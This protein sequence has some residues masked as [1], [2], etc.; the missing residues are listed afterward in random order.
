MSYQN[1]RNRYLLMSAVIAAGFLFALTFIS[2]D[3]DADDVYPE[4]GDFTYKIDISG[5]TAGIY[6]YNGTAGTVE[7]PGSVTYEGRS[8]SIV[9]ICDGAFNSKDVISVSIP[10]GVETIGDSAF[11][12]CE[13]LTT[14]NIPDSVT[15]L[16]WGCFRT[17]TALE[18]VTFG[19]DP[20]LTTLGSS[21]FNHCYKLAS[22]TIPGGVTV[23]NSGTFEGCS[24]FTAVSIHDGITSIEDNAF[25]DC[26]GLTAVYF[27]HS[28]QLA[29]IDNEAFS[30]CSGLAGFSLP[31]TVTKV[32]Y[33]AFRNTA[34]TAIDLSNVTDLGAEA[35]EF[36]DELNTVR[37]NSG[38][39]TIEDSL[40]EG[41]SGLQSIDI[42]A[43]VTK[44]GGSA[45]EECA[46]LTSVAIPYGVERIGGYA[47]R[48]CERLTSII[49]PDSVT[50]IGG[51]CFDGC[52][53]AT[54][55]HISTGM[56]KIPFCAFDGLESLESLTIPGNI[57]EIDYSFNGCTKLSYLNIEEGLETVSGFCGCAFST[58]TLPNS[59]IRLEDFDGCKDLTT[60]N[61]G[62][63]L[64]DFGDYRPFQNCPALSEFTVA[65]GNPDFCTADGVLY[66]DGGSKLRLYPQGKTDVSFSIPSQVSAANVTAIGNRAFMDNPYL[67]NITI[68]EGVTTIE[69]HAILECYL[70]SISFPDSLT[71]VESVVAYCLDFYYNDTS[72]E[73]SQTAENLKGKMWCGN[74]K[75]GNFASLYYFDSVQF[76]VTFRSDSTVVKEIQTNNYGKLSEALPTPPEKQGYTFKGWF[77]SIPGGVQVTTDIVFTKDSN[78]YADWEYEPIPVAGVSLDKTSL[79]LKK[80]G[81][82][83]L[84]AT[85]TPSGASNKDVTWSSSDPS[86]ASVSEYGLVSANA[87]GK[88][89]ITVTTVSGGYTATCEVTVNGDGP[90]PSPGGGDSGGFPWIII[91]VA[92]IIIAAT[93]GFYLYKK[94]QQ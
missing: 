56:S 51:Y 4:I 66:S 29:T 27:G 39:T 76:T 91:V 5:T 43:G 20:Q 50:S 1:I 34:I 74:G 92:V 75:N 35:F 49:I 72:T 65:S 79:T 30:G 40:F 13:K 46:A 59:V 10:E 17:C 18:T 52:K 55:L 45:F 14:V 53:N 81:T 25:E 12:Y 9:R 69:E 32:G 44:I 7:I 84:T 61:I 31:S 71:A 60:V 85:V 28:P 33:G 89:A 88:A 41:C 80:G 57:K 26:T 77:T 86:V 11:Q 78:V 23:I 19:T 3:T 58:L 6:A 47:F 68:P 62:T 82:D 94:K 93:A 2:A 70:R 38:L 83:R 16:G 8:Y 37:L 54:T 48:D 36:C 90:S 15:E 64:T 21:A 67:E 22:F 87:A 42:P 63:G 24:S 73:I